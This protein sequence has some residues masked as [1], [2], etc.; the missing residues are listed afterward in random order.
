[1]DINRRNVAIL[2]LGQALGMSGPPI[3][4]L[5]GGILGADLAPRPALATLP[6]SLMVIGVALSTVPAAMIMKRIGRRRGFVAASLLASVG[7]LTAAY[8]VARGSFN[9]LILASLLIGGNGAFIQQYRF[10]AAES[11]T[12]RYTG[13]AVAFVLLGGILAGYLGP[14]VAQRARDWLPAGTY[15]GSFAAL[16]IMYLAVAVLMVFLKEIAPQST[17]TAGEARSMREIAGQRTYLVAVL[18]AAVSYGV[19]SFIMTATP[20]QLHRIEGFTMQ[21]TATVIQSHIVAMYLPSLF[22]GFLIERLGVSRVLAAGVTLLSASVIVGLISRE[23]A[24]F[25]IA[26][27]LLGVGWNFLF[28]GGTVLLTRSYRT[29][30]RFR[31]QA[32]NDFTVFGVQALASSSAGAVLFAAN[33]E[34]LN[35]MALPVLG[36]TAVA[37]WLSRKQFAPLPTR[38]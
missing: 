18:A 9:L 31:A 27:V 8:A 17:E 3:I 21:N 37:I 13:R 5:L 11:A 25:W 20:I 16:A 15:T 19:M 1:M 24:H 14:E 12:A 34:T 35:L 28:V 22:S 10:A 7:S 38:A 26:L 30:E 23:L 32:A 36:L 29:A 4:V 2:S 6:I 33:W